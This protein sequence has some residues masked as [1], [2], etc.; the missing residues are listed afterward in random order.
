MV[1]LEYLNQLKSLYTSGK[2]EHAIRYMDW[3]LKEGKVFTIATKVKKKKLRQCYYN[4][5]II[6]LED[7]TIAYYE[8]WGITKRV[9]I[10]LEHGFNVKDGKIM[11]ATWRDGELYF[12]VHIPTDYI[13]KQWFKTKMSEALL[14]RYFFEVVDK[15]SL[16]KSVCMV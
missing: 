4:A 11:D 10:P 15:K 2:Q 9:G 1:I 8:G 13:R 7:D 12:G 3:V 14:T 6:A 5:Q 16:Q